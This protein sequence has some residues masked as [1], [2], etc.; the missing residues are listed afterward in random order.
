MSAALAL[1]VVPHDEISAQRTLYVVH[2]WEDRHCPECGSLT[3]H[4]Q[5]NCYER[6]DEN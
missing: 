5:K 1:P 4:H 6:W 3:P 2:A